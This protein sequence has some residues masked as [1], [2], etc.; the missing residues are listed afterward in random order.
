[1]TISEDG[2]YVAGVYY[3]EW[4][5]YYEILEVRKI[6]DYSLVFREESKYSDWEPNFAPYQWAT[7]YIFEFSKDNK[8]LV[9]TKNKIYIYNLI[10]GQTIFEKA[11]NAKQ[12][13]FSNNNILFFLRRQIDDDKSEKIK[14][15]IYDCNN[16]I[17]L[18]RDFP[19]STNQLIF[20][21]DNIVF[22]NNYVLCHMLNKYNKSTN[23]SGFAD[24]ALLSLNFDLTSIEN[25]IP[26]SNGILYPNPATE[27][28]TVEVPNI[29]SLQGIEIYN[30][31]GEC[32]LSVETGLRPVSTKI[33]VSVLPPGLYFMKVGNAKPMKFMVVR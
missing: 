33:D 17:Y 10:T 32:V 24:I 9:L 20:H 25:K 21:S 28:I 22:N 19:D 6:S 12:S 27:Y 1:M 14:A 15:C 13:T 18:E 16:E 3:K 4:G 8:Y 29:E 26:E 7:K 11:G 2:Q 31:F 5:G 30:I 23:Y